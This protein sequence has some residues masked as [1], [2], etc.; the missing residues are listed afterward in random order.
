[1]LEQYVPNFLLN[2]ISIK[3]FILIILIYFFI[4]YIALIFW[5]IKDITSRTDSIV[6]QIIAIFLVIIFNFFGWLIYLLIRPAHTIYE[7]FYDEVNDNLE[8]LTKNIFN[9]LQEKKKKKKK[10]N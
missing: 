10:K 8:N 9:K 5:T 6:F 4:L 3:T 1:M 7:K 2:I